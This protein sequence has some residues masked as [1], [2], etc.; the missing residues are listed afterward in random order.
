MDENTK[1]EIVDNSKTF[2]DVKEDNW[3]NPAIDFV[4]SHEIFNG[5][6]D[7]TFAPEATMTRGMLVQVLYNFENRPEGAKAGDFGDVKD[8]A[9]FADAVAWAAD[10]KIVAGVGDNSFAPE[11]EI[12]REQLVTILYRYAGE[13]KPAGSLDQFSDASQVKDY[14]QDAML[15][16]VENGIVSGMG[17][18]TLAPQGQ[19]T[20]AQVAQIMMNF[21]DLIVK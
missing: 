3:A 11:Q 19:A 6:G 16:A 4:T 14:A 15:W 17:D 10:N 13:P 18:N 9:W 20:R 8:D 1:L 12:S 2:N 21:C 5:T 7:S